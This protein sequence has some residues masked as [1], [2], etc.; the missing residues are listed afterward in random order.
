MRKGR[1]D[2][3]NSLQISLLASS[4]RIFFSPR[5]PNHGGPAAARDRGRRLSGATGLPGLFFLSEDTHNLI[6]DVLGLDA[7]MCDS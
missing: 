2:G 4:K 6:L 1:D 7:D 5:A 3:P